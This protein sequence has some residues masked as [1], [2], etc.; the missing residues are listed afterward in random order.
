MG[1]WSLTNEQDE[2]DYRGDSRWGN[3]T[4]E[5]RNGSVTIYFKG[6]RVGQ[7]QLHP[8]FPDENGSAAPPTGDCDGI[9]ELLESP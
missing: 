2:N 6:L 7:H 3:H 9:A 8:A 5:A 1:Q 4:F